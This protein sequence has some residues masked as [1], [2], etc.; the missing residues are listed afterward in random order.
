MSGCLPTSS[1]LRLR[2]HFFQPCDYQYQILGPACMEPHL[3]KPG[4]VLFTRYSCYFTYF[5]RRYHSTCQYRCCR[6][7]NA[8]NHDLYHAFVYWLYRMKSQLALHLWDIL[9]LFRTAHKCNYRHPSEKGAVLT[10]EKHWSCRPHCGGT[11]NRLLEEFVNKR[12]CDWNNLR[13]QAK[14]SGLTLQ[15]QANSS[16]FKEKVW[17]SEK[18]SGKVSLPEVELSWN[19]STGRQRMC[20]LGPQGR[21]LRRHNRRRVKPWCHPIFDLQ[22]GT[23]KK[24]AGT[25]PHR[26]DAEA[27]AKDGRNLKNLAYAV[28]HSEGSRQ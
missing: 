18:L 24:I 27:T 1:L 23:K 20:S 9:Q 28:R 26:I 4:S 17:A 11:E 19:I 25:P 14:L 10:N 7:F 5:K 8:V 16:H 12:I 22:S 13:I 21:K 2:S 15:Q 3:E 6:R